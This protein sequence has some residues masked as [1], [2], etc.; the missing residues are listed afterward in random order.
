MTNLRSYLR[1]CDEL[2]DQFRL[3][4]FYDSPPE[5]CGG[6]QAETSYAEKSEVAENTGSY[7]DVGNGSLN[8]NK[9]Q[10]SHQS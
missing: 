10:R 8:A 3:A 2:K 9:E 4:L 1:V 5:P 7:G 6:S